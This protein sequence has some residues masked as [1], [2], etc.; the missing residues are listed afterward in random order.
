MK[1]ELSNDGSIFSDE[2]KEKNIRKNI[3]QNTNNDTNKN[4]KSNTDSRW[5]DL[6][7]RLISAF[8]LVSSYVILILMGHFYCTLFL[9]FI[10]YQIFREIISL[11][12]YD[13]RNK[14]IKNMNSISWTFF[15]IGAYGVYFY[16]LSEQFNYLKKYKIC[17]FLF[18][19]HLFICFILWACNFFRFFLNLQKGVMRYQIGQLGLVHFLFLIFTIPTGLMYYNLMNGFIWYI[20]PIVMIIVNDTFAYICGRAFGRHQLTVISPKKTWEGYLG[21]IIFTVISGFFLTKLAMKYD[22]LVCPETK[23]NLIPFD[24]LNLKCDSSFIKEVLYSYDLKYYT[25]EITRLHIHTTVICLFAS[26]YGPMGGLFASSFKRSIGIKDFSDFIPGHG[27]MT[28]RMDC[29]FIMSAFT[30]VYLSTFLFKSN[31][32]ENVLENID[33]MNNEDKL[34]IL[35][36]FKNM[37]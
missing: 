2:Q 34:K 29:Q 19:Y 18:N 25:I 36:Y 12:N 9:I 37:F 32:V 15:W 31:K 5:K 8:I 6:S 20:F 24:A 3:K 23:I 14:S 17:E 28:D 21:A 35:K 11:P 1:D 16:S 4:T 26:V 27:G 33:T 22:F 30:Y 10:I 7:Q 13:K